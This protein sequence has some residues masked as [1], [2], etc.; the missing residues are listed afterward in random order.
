[1]VDPSE[2]ARLGE[3]AGIAVNGPQL[4]GDGP[5][6]SMVERS[7]DDPARAATEDALHDVT[8]VELRSRTP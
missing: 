2:R 5:T 4:E 7:H 6:Q 3:H 1:M 8:V